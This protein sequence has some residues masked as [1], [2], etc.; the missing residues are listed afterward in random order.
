M[1]KYILQRQKKKK[2][3]LGVLE[4][5][6]IREKDNETGFAREKSSEIKT[7]VLSMYA[8]HSISLFDI[9]LT[10]LF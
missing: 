7:T 9:I 8:M 4:K 5:K 10:K 2:T 1:S 6:E 3:C